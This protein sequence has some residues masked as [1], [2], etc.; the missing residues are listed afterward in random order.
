MKYDN[1]AEHLDD[2]AKYAA[3][4]I[5]ARFPLSDQDDLFQEIR[6]YILKRPDMIAD[7][8]Q[9]YGNGKAETVH[10]ARKLMARMR[11]V[12]ER[13]A[14]K[15]KA[16]ITGYQWNDEFFYDS[17]HIADLLPA[18]LVFETN[19]DMLVDHVDDGQPKRPSAPAEGNNLLAMILDVRRA[20]DKLEQDD[21][22]LLEQRY[23]PGSLTLQQIAEAW[24]TTDSTID[25]RVQKAIRLM[26]QHL[27][28]AN[29]WS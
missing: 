22:I 19:G 6:I 29:P 3:R 27:G 18:A 9:A 2:L 8:E 7:L 20:Y 25:R 14:R 28:G 10:M 13:Y 21:Q 23:G 12:A 11:R 24:N 4:D 5:S 15:E 16:A 1:P 26:V 17:M